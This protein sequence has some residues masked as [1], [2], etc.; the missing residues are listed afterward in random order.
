MLVAGVVASVVSI[1][2]VAARNGRAVALEEARFVADFGLVGDWRSRSRR[3]R[4]I[5]LVEAE[6]MEAMALVL[7]VEGIPPGASRR[8]VLVRGIA[9]GE[10]IGRRLRLGEIVVQVDEPCTPC[11][12]MDRQMG[13]GARLAMAGCGGVVG[14]VVEGGLVRP[15]DAIEVDP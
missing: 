2:R 5:S 13:A 3:G 11:A 4:Q 12:N 9:L 6:A 7:G 1:H 14:R 15:G 8:Q 10:A